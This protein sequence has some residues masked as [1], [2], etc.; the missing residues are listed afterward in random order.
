MASRLRRRLVGDGEVLEHRSP[1]ARVLAFPAVGQSQ[2]RL[3]KERA[4]AH[5]NPGPGS[6]P[7]WKQATTVM[8]SRPLRFD[9]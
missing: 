2:K 4:R 5:G 1:L 8:A 6:R 9:S 7:A 3:A